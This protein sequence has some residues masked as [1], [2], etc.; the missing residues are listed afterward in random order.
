MSGGQ[1]FRGQY[2]YDGLGRM[3]SEQ[4]PKTNNSAY[5]YTFDTVGT[6]GTSDGDVVKRVDPQHTV[7]CYGFGALHRLKFVTH[8]RRR[9]L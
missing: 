1:S 2:D 9:V 7:T 5:T 8:P 6:Y 3:T 4:N